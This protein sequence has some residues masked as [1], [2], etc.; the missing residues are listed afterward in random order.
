M[1]KIILLVSCLAIIMLIFCACDSGTANISDN[2]NNQNNLQDTQQNREI[3]QLNKTN[4]QKYI[5]IYVR[6]VDTTYYYDFVGSTICKFN[7]VV[8]NFYLSDNAD[9]IPENATLYSCEL[10]ISG[11]GQ[12]KQTGYSS[13]YGSAYIMIIESVTGT[14][15]IL[16]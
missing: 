9:T 3:I 13:K 8:V 12:A 5:A 16:Y 14:V 7:N 6:R 10:T 15:E 1:K 11:C 4:Y 2:Q